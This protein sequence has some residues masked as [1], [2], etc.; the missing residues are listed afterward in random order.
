[1]SRQSRQKRTRPGTPTVVDLD[2]F[3]SGGGYLHNSVELLLTQEKSNMPQIN[4]TVHNLLLNSIIAKSSLLSC[5]YVKHPIINYTPH[6]HP[7]EFGLSKSSA[8]RILVVMLCWLMTDLNDRLRMR[9]R[10][11]LSLTDSATWVSS[12]YFA[13]GS[14]K[15]LN[16]NVYFNLNDI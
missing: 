16:L 5:W 8:E 10:E 3:L 2:R 12:S 14:L 1:M 6:P 9:T 13:K 15:K 4:T 11:E 7:T